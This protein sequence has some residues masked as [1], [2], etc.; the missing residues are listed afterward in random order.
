MESPH[1]YFSWYFSPH[2]MEYI[3]YQTNLYASQKDINTTFTTGVDE[4]MNFVAILTYMGIVQLPSVADYWAMETRVPQVANI[5]SLKRFCMMKRMVHFNDNAQI[6]GTINRFFK[7]RPLF[8]FLTT[9]FRSE[10][11]TPKQSVDEVMVAYKGKTAGNLRQYIK[12]K[13]LKWGFKLFARASEDGFVHNVVLYQGKMT[14]EAHDVPQHC[15]QQ[16][17][18]WS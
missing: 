7:I 5:M 1:Q 10:Q 4:M 15:R 11:Q 2:V 12:N 18:E 13:P 17:W 9:A 16:T 8:S 14:A 6:C 3:T